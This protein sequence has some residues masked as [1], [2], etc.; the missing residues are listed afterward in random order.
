MQFEIQ[1]RGK[2]KKLLQLVMPSIIK[3][4]NLTSSKKMVIVTV[5]PDC[6]D[7][8]LMV[9]LPTIDGYFV[10]LRT[11]M[12]IDK[13]GIVLGHEMTHVYQMAKGLLKQVN[14]TS[15]WRGRKFSKNTPYL[16]RPWE[17]QA[18]QKQEL[19]FRRALLD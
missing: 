9:E 1:A 7:D 14:G 2:S 18:F 12:D 17:I 13:L 6:D 10:V 8:G 16:S 15:F 5:Q 11:G 3:Q 4:L 19:L